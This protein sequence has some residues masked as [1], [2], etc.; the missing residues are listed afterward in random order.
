MRSIACRMF[1]F[2]VCSDWSR[3]TQASTWINTVAPVQRSPRT[4]LTKSGA[5]I[6]RPSSAG[7]EKDATTRTA[8]TQT[9]TSRARSSAMR[10]KAGKST[11]VSGPA[12]RLKGTSIT[13]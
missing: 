3:P 9:D 8:R 4:T 2:S 12:M 6:T 11:S 10:L 5:T 13:L 7:T 1:G